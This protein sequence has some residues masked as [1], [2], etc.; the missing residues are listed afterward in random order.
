MV[1]KTT[2]HQTHKAY[3]LG[4]M[5]DLPTGCKEITRV[6]MEGETECMCKG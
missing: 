5:T 6:K 2:G 4:V 1:N 3:V